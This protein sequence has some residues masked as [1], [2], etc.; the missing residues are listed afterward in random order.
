MLCN[1]PVPYFPTPKIGAVNKTQ[2]DPAAEDQLIH[3]KQF[4]LCLL[5]DTYVP[6]PEARI[7]H[8]YGELC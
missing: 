3:T 1:L 6:I 7:W 5:K 2:T 8:I 4:K